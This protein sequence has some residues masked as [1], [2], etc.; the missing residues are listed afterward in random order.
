M[1]VACFFV[2][3]AAAVGQNPR[4]N[5]DVVQQ[6]MPSGVPTDLARVTEREKPLA[7]ERLKS[8]Q[9]DATGKRA[10]QVAFLLAHLGFQYAKNRDYLLRTLYGC[11]THKVSCDEDTAM[12]VIALYEDGDPSVLK[13]L[14]RAG[15]H[16]DAALSEVL[17]DFYADVLIKNT[18]TFLVNVRVFPP[19]QQR[20]LCESAG[21]RD[22][23]GMSPDELKT[24]QVRLKEINGNSALQCAEALAKA[25]AEANKQ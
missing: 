19:V 11:R 18:R 15:L 9:V 21:W 16:S 12:F 24:V 13:A 7:V 2:L 3:A 5:T 4:P 17:G 20:A 23:G 14:L 22:G 25:V 1:T 6:L 10:Q 8:A